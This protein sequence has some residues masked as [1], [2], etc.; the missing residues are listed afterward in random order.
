[1]EK[2]PKKARRKVRCARSGKMFSSLAEAAEYFGVSDT[3][4]KLH[5]SGKIRNPR[6]DIP[7]EFMEEDE[8]RVDL[9]SFRKELRDTLAG[10]PPGANLIAWATQRI[11][12]FLKS[13]TRQLEISFLPRF[14]VSFNASAQNLEIQWHPEDRTKL[15]KD[16]S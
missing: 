5:A 15:R 14:R 3:T 6:V 16:L 11:D 4:I 1:M 7:V 2:K 9:A 13:K 8:G 12:T 10:P